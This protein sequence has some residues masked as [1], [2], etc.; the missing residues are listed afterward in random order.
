[1]G[2]WQLGVR[3]GLYETGGRSAETEGA[4]DGG[5][6]GEPMR[7][8]G[9]GLEVE[10]GNDKLQL[11]KSVTLRVQCTHQHLVQV[12]THADDLSRGSN[13]QWSSQKSV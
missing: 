3:R 5:E 1:M 2:S 9:G 13:F 11:A 6:Q 8:P 7:F 10:S 12:S 4:K